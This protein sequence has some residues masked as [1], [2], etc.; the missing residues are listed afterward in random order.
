MGTAMDCAIVY[1]VPV[2]ALF[3]NDPVTDHLV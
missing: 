2:E 1:E 3:N